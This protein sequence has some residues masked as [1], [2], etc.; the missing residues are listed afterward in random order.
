M[1]ENK[2]KYKITKYKFSNIK[3]III[4]KQSTQKKKIILKKR[5]MPKKQK[6]ISFKKRSI[7]PIIR[8]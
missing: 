5:I 1:K 6:I 3:T 7:K 8:I 4:I 2:I